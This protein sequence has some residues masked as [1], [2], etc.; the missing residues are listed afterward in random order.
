MKGDNQNPVSGQTDGQWQYAP[1]GQPVPA[2]LTSSS[3]PA[4]SPG[5]VEWSASEFVAHN[6]DASWYAILGLGA[7]AFAA[8]IY[9]FTHDTTSAAII[10]L[11]ALL[12]GISGARKPRVLQ[13]RV[14]GS[15][16][17]IGNKFY[18]YAEFKSFSVMQ[19]GAFSSIMFLPLKRF[20]PP[21]SIY[22][23]P[24][25]EDNIVE[26]LAY[27]LPMEARSHDMIDGLI[28]RIRF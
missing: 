22:Y 24:K 27:Y 6:K 16:L 11:V 8:V 15:G 21:L 26:V 28:R 25:D 9:F 13:Y 2:S 5:E 3:T 1:Q 4:G 7:V 10:V 23:E 12:L 18:S 20:M 17:A 19:E 14:N